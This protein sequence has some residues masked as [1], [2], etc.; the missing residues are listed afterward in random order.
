MT[1]SEPEFGSCG[2]QTSD[3]DFL[4][5][6]VD[7][8]F[9]QCNEINGDEFYTLNTNMLPLSIRDQLLWLS[10]KDNCPALNESG[11]LDSDSIVDGLSSGLFQNDICTLTS[12]E[13]LATFTSSFTRQN[14]AAT[15]YYNNNV[16]CKSAQVVIPVYM[17]VCH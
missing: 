4:I 3:I 2:T 16:S 14:I 10:S 17:Y 5:D 6:A 7:T 12:G 8:S 1:Y 15:I 9:V 13:S 11:G